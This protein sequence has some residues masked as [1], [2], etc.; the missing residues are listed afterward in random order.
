MD[1]RWEG[2]SANLRHRKTSLRG[3]SFSEGSRIPPVWPARLCCV[4]TDIA[5]S[6]ISVRISTCGRVSLPI[7]SSPLYLKFW[8]IVGCTLVSLR[9]KRP[10]AHKS[11]DR[12]FMQR[13]L[14]SSAVS[15]TD[16]DLKRHLLLRSMRKRG[17]RP[18]LIY[19]EWAETWLLRLQAA[20]DGGR[21]YPEPA[22]SQL[23]GRLWL[24]VCWYTAKDEGWTAC[25]RFWR[26]A[27][28]R[29][30]LQDLRT[31]VSSHLS[32]LQRTDP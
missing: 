24:N 23:L 9:N 31:S 21:C 10:L 2:S 19:L 16:T 11:D 27:L 20:N 8:C 7:T 5:K 25:R 12:L 3:G 13:N 4:R 14:K 29:T 26:S 18:D 32:F 22:F 30:A 15:V 6:S 17:F 28:R 1:T